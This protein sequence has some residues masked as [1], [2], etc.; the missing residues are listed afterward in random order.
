MVNKTKKHNPKYLLYLAFISGF[1]IMAIELAASRL[2]SPS[3]GNSLFVW[4]NII[5]LIMIFL[6]LGYYFGGRIADKNPDPLMIIRIIFIAGVIVFIIPFILKPVV[7]L[8]TI[9]STS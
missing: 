6:S 9:K 8:T 2:L 5:G 4:T 1:S 7:S 3:F